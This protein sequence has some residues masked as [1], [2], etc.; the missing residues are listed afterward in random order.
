MQKNEKD[1]EA[2]RVTNNPNMSFP[3][4]YFQNL[5]CFARPFWSH[6]FSDYQPSYCYSLNQRMHLGF[7]HASQDVSGSAK[8]LYGTSQVDKSAWSHSLESKVNLF[9]TWNGAPFKIQEKC[10]LDIPNDL[11]LVEYI[12]KQIQ[13]SLNSHILGEKNR[14]VLKATMIGNVPTQIWESLQHKAELESMLE[15][16]ESSGPVHMN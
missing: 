7:K 5:K 16:L 2:I 3:F 12:P 9:G 11:H 10:L 8:L 6:V 14:L 1:P 13:Y 4:V 15:I